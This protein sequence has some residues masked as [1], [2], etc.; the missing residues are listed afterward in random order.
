[1]KFSY[2]PIINWFG[3]QSKTETKTTKPVFNT[4]P[5]SISR[6]RKDIADWNKALQMAML[7][8]NPKTWSLYNLLD[9]ILQ[10]A[11]LKSQVEN[12]KNKS[13]SQTFS[14]VGKD[15]KIN[16][17]ITD[18]LQNQIFENEVNSEILNTK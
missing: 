11:L 6:V 7:E 1:M 12:R 8:E 4:A 10:D 17:E 13:L 15:G 5:K 2:R 18:L 9:E 16:K 3:L 14:I